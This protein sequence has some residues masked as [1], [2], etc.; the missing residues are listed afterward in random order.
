ME[1]DAAD[2]QKK[3]D[4][5]GERLSRLENVSVAW[6]ETSKMNI[7][8]D[9]TFIS[10]LNVRFVLAVLRILRSVTFFFAWF[11][12]VLGCCSTVE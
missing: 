12:L 9:S 11:V 2:L 4:D 7:A 6:A 10:W 8:S 3:V 5:S 1:K